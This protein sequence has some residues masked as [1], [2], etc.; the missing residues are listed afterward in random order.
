MIVILVYYFR[1]LF[2]RLVRSVEW[3]VSRNK[4]AL[5]KGFELYCN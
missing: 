3:F 5:K 4:K 2:A 1:I